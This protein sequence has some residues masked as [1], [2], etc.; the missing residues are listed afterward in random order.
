M[1]IESKEEKV[2]ELFLN[3]PTKHWHFTEIMSSAEVSRRVAS[4][5]LNKLMD[6]KIINHI[7]PK[8]KMPYFQ[9]NFR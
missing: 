2:L 4:R 3:E 8:A 6:K 1:G 5:W 9:R 7:K